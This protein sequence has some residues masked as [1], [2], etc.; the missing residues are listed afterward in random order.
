MK[1]AYIE[2]TGVPEVIQVGDLPT[3]VPSGQEVLV[4][5]GAASVNPIDTY[6][7]G[8]VIGMA[9]QFPYIPGCDLAGTVEAVGPGVQRF[10]AGDR[11]W[12]SNQS[13]FGRQGTYAEFA[14]VDEAWLYP[15]PRGQSD[16]S[17]AAGALV[18]ITAQLGLFLHAGLAPG[19][20]V[21]VNGGSGGVGSAV[22]QFAA[23]AGAHVIASAG[24]EFNREYCRSLGAEVVLDYRS[25][26]IDDEIREA[27]A[28]NKG[29]DLWWETQREPDFDRI[30]GHLKRRGRI[31]LMAGRAARPEFPV[32][33]F[34]VND[35]RMFGFAMFNASPDEQRAAAERMNAEFELGRWAPR[36]GCRFA[37]EETGAAHRLQ[38]DNT[39]GGKRTL[40]GKIVILP[41]GS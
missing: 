39:L 33:P 23:A 31:V 22:I 8:G 12:G 11:V 18:G 5:I 24:S 27:A 16:E 7:R 25:G 15:T 1:A 4:R 40:S 9:S 17:A 34:Y 26:T 20:W 29:V 21:Y 35:L 10:K 2:Q 14:A 36:I 3:P 19:D 41:S 37:L 30:V 28:G 32:G 38:E 6:I 13:L